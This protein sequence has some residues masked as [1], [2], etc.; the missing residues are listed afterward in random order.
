[1]VIKVLIL[2]WKKAV[3]FA[4]RNE[5]LDHYIVVFRIFVFSVLNF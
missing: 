4:V 5:I 3:L 2:S 1:M